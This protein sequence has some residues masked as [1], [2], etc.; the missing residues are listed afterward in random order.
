MPDAQPTKGTINI[1]TLLSKLGPKFKFY[2]VLGSISK[3][4]VLLVLCLFISC[5]LVAAAQGVVFPG[6]AIVFGEL[7]N[8][9]FTSNADQIRS[10]SQIIAGVFVALAVYNLVTGYLGQMLWGMVGEEVGAYYRKE[11]FD[12]V[13]RQEVRH[14]FV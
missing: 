13:L 10:D 9:F 8:I 4:F 11:F 12:S 2:M 3:L 7:F 5:V 6:F 1:T 14:Q